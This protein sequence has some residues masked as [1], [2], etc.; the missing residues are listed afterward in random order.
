MSKLFL[1]SLV[2]LI[3]ICNT[4][5]LGQL[6]IVTEEDKV[7]GVDDSCSASVGLSAILKCDDCP[8]D[9]EVKWEVLVDIYGDWSYDYVFSSFVDVNDDNYGTSENELYLIPTQVNDTVGISLPKIVPGS[10]YE[11]RVIYKASLSNGDFI[12]KTETFSVEDVTPPTIYCIDNYT[13]NVQNNYS[14]EL[15]SCDLIIGIVDNC[16]ANSSMRYTFTMPA[17][18]GEFP[19]VELYEDYCEPMTFECNGDSESVTIPVDIYVWDE[20]DNSEVCSF[21]L[22]LENCYYEAPYHDFSLSGSIISMNDTPIPNAEVT[23]E[24]NQPEYP[25]TISTDSIGEFTSSHGFYGSFIY[26]F[27]LSVH[28]DDKLIIGLDDNDLL[29]LQ[30]HL[31]GSEPF[32]QPFQYVAADLDRNNAVD[33]SDLDLLGSIIDQSID[34]LV[35]NTDWRFHSK[36]ITWTLDDPFS[37][38]ETINIDS[39][40]EDLDSLDFVGVKMGDIDGSFGSITSSINTVSQNAQFKVSDNAPNPFNNSTTFEISAPTERDVIMDVFNSIGKKVTSAK[41]QLSTQTQ[42]I[43]VLNDQL[44]ESGI[45]YCRF[46]FGDAVITKQV[47]YLEK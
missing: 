38:E 20:F 23:I 44:P 45:Y 36:N 9:E 19:N 4:K 29:R 26:L 3:S 10:K 47:I 35:N 15:W 11:H 6:A 28:K 13:V 14:V 27:T 7:I 31:D 37:I 18:E 43:E 32:T 2:F 46:Q 8:I 33:Q 39:L 34:T 5:L 17:T 25:W 41:H 16:S 24:S 40:S 42:E 21:I 1:S 22:T 12:S 30:R